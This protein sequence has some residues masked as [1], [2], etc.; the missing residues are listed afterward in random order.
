MYSYLYL[1]LDYLNKTPH[2]E[3]HTFKYRLTEGPVKMQARRCAEKERKD[4]M[5]GREPM[6]RLTDHKAG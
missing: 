1:C 4:E 5:G 6:E 2:L 3:I